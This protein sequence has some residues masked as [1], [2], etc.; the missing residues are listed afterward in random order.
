MSNIDKEL[1]KMAHQACTDTNCRNA[2]QLYLYFKQAY[3]MG[4]DNGWWQMLE[5][6]EKW[7]EEFERS[8]LE[9]LD[10]ILKEQNK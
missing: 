5:E 9:D 2:E 10:Y 3:Q 7:I 8:N 1:Q 6:D 4:C